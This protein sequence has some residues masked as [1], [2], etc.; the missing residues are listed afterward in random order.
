MIPTMVV[1]ASENENLSVDV[2]QEEV[3]K[4]LEA[5]SNQM[6][7]KESLFMLIKRGDAHEQ[8]T[9][10]IEGIKNDTINYYEADLYG[11]NPLHLALKYPVLEPLAVALINKDARLLLQQDGSYRYPEDMA[12]GETGEVVSQLRYEAE[13][14][15]EK[16]KK[17]I[18]PIPLTNLP[19]PIKKLTHDAFDAFLNG[20]EYD[21]GNPLNE[22]YI[23]DFFHVS[24]AKSSTEDKPLYTVQ[25]KKGKVIADDVASYEYYSCNNYY[26]IIHIKHQDNKQS[27]FD[28]NG[29]P[30]KDAYRTKNL[31]I[32]GSKEKSIFRYHV[33][34][35]GAISGFH[36]V[37]PLKRYMRKLASL[38]A[39][40]LAGSMIINEGVKY[41]QKDSAEQGREDQQP[42]TLIRMEGPL[43]LF[44]T[45]GDKKP[46]YVGQPL[47]KT[48]QAFLSEN[49]GQTKK[50]GSWK[51]AKGV[52]LKRY[53]QPQ[54][55]KE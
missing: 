32:F 25:N 47:D 45:D 11:Q 1:D 39:I 21:D 43:A 13:L 52:S 36:R 2:N 38:A 22:A 27:L 37:Y 19:I 49:V 26:D 48:G 16:S 18:L 17:T 41:I 10:M 3:M 29:Q 20:E 15:W 31:T 50:I 35:Q 23:S 55:E 30:L 8:M 7:D 51:G 4:E 53:N 46:D 33:S 14:L 28:R 34:E 24:R 6:S 5:R 40:G 54:Q 9:Q 42:A 44:D 12:K